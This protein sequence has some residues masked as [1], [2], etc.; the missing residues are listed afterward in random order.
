MPTPAWS[1]PVRRSRGCRRCSTATPEPLIC[2]REVTAAGRST[3]RVD[4]VA[5]TAARLAD[6]AG[7][8]VEIHGQHD[9]QRLLRCLAPARPARRA[10]RARGPAGGRGGGGGGLAGEPGGP[11]RRLRGIRGQW[12]GNSSCTGTRRSRSRRPA[13]GRARSTRSASAWPRPPAPCRWSACSP[14]CASDWR[15]RGPGHA[16]CWRASPGTA[17][18]LARL[19]GRFAGL[20]ER[21]EA[22]ARRGGRRGVRAATRRRRPRTTTRPR[23]R[24]LEERLGLIY[25]LERKYGPDEEAVLAHGA[26]ARAAAER[27]QGLE[28]ERAARAADD[29]RLEAAARE[30]ATALTD[31]AAGGRGRGSPPRCRRALEA[32]GLPAGAARRGAGAGRRSAPPVPR[33]CSS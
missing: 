9:Q 30:A 14:R 6:V 29:V 27:L 3:A 4:D 24:A 23:W 20:A 16:T 11:G 31:G 25:A 8:L 12:P 2:V 18:D 7:P 19:D 32:L 15:G 1:G 5:V 33:R 28:A 17:A 21:I 13:C 22:L 26:R 10:R